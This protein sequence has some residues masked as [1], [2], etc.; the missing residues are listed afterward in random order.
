MNNQARSFSDSTHEREVY[1][2]VKRAIEHKLVLRGVY[3][4]LMRELCPH[5]LGRKNG[6]LQ[7]LFYQ[8]G[9]ESSSGLAAP[10]STENWRCIPLAGLTDVTTASGYWATAPN[11]SRPQTCVDDIH[12]EVSY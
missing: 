11:H 8:S 3:R 5:V 1:A 10:G 4:G 12:V 9:G 2:V 7:A 6:R